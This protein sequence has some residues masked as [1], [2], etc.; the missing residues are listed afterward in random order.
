MFD[1]RGSEQ[2]KPFLLHRLMFV[3]ESDKF[4]D[5]DE[6]GSAREETTNISGLSIPDLIDNDEEIFSG[7]DPLGEFERDQVLPHLK[8]Q[9]PEPVRTPSPR[10]KRGGRRMNMLQLNEVSEDEQQ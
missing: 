2:I 4:S 6:E 9:S 7:R 10:R 1:R 3:S 5:L 8:Y